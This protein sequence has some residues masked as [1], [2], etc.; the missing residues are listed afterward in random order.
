MITSS[1][2][3]QHV[4]EDDGHRPAAGA[5]RVQIRRTIGLSMKASSQARKK[6]RMTSPKAKKIG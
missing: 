2:D 5:A 6:I 3:D 4:D 1:P